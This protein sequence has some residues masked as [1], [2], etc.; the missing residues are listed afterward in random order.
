MHKIIQHIFLGKK[1]TIPKPVLNAFQV[2]F[3]SS[4]NVE[5]HKEKNLFEA[6]FYV[7]NM[8]HIAIFSADGILLEKKCNLEL[9]KVTP[10]ISE[11][12]R[13]VGELMNLIEISRNGKIFY[14][15]I[16]RDSLLNRYSLLM[17]ENGRLLEKKKL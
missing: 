13:A 2:K 3:G 12:A 9:Q 11:Q 6:V 15:I 14:E 16:A 7:S 1:P 8:E 10:P 5:W 4:I 17:E